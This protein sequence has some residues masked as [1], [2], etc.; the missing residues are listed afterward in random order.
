MRITL[1]YDFR[2]LKKL[3]YTH[4]LCVQLNRLT[5]LTLID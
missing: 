2:K 1:D 3:M 4:I 5:V